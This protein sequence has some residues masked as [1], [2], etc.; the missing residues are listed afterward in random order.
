MNF[1]QWAGSL[2]ALLKIMSI[3]GDVKVNIEFQDPIEKD[4]FIQGIRSEVDM[5]NMWPGVRTPSAIT[6]MLSCHPFKWFGIEYKLS[7]KS[8]RRDTRMS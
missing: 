7:C 5:S 8:E 2:M 6:Q 4:K 3:R 1:V